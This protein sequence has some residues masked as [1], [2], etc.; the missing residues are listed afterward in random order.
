MNQKLKKL[1]KNPLW[2]LLIKLNEREKKLK[3]HRL[4]KFPRIF[5]LELPIVVIIMLTFAYFAI[6]SM[7]MYGQVWRNDNFYN[8]EYKDYIIDTMPFAKDINYIN[9]VATN[10]LKMGWC[11]SNVCELEFNR[12]VNFHPLIMN[13]G[14][15]YPAIKGNCSLITYSNP[16]PEEIHE[17]DV[18]TYKDPYLDIRIIHRVSKIITSNDT[19]LYCF[20]GDNDKYG[21]GCIEFDAIKEKVLSVIC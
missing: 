3:A 17:G 18:L 8:N 19:I 14:S 12:S 16:T 6:P 4:K 10:Y 15:M 5:L 1:Y 7:V 9:N 13:T 20:Q 2:R 11:R 21:D